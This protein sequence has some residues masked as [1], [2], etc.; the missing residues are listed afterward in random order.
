MSKLLK[1]FLYLFA[2]GVALALLP[3]TIGIFLGWLV[4]KRVSNKKVKIGIIAIISV[5]T[6]FFGS[7]WV[8]ALNST[9]KQSPK[10]TPTVTPTQSV[11]ASPSAIVTET[12]KPELHK[13]IKVIDGDTIDVDING[14]TETIRM[15]GIDSPESVD[16]RK[17]VQCFA[18]EASNKAK[19][20]LTG[21]NVSLEADPTQGE[22]DKY[23][24]LLRFVFLEDS[25]NFNKFM[26]SEGYA[27]EYTYQSNPYKYQEEFKL[28]ETTARETKK[29]LWADNACVSPTPAPTK[30]T[31]STVAPAPTKT[32]QV[33][34]PTQST[35]NTTNAGGNGSYACDC[36]KSCAAISSCDEA[37]YQLN[38][39][40]CSARDGDSDGVPCES[41]C[42]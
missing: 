3:V 25:T 26:I 39:C 1:F 23:N 31:V 18:I 9:N 38:T 19:E 33:V 24:R 29:G 42:R 8:V 17:P 41:L 16:P 35:S 22:Q 2:F 20:K 34:Q 36:S 15:I 7:A 13:V 40:G 12:P 14:K 10:P 30:Q 4:F 5:L 11:T 32:T 6:L 27:H 28:A 21:K 37:Y